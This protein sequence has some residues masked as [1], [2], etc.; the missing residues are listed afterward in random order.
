M[1][2]ETASAC[3]YNTA[4]LALQKVLTLTCHASRSMA[5]LVYRGYAA[6]MTVVG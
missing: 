2:V 1:A 3:Y 4:F 5:G 6:A